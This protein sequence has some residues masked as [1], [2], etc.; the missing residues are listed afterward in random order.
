MG[1]IILGMTIALGAL[2][3]F[4]VGL[5]SVGSGAILTPILLIDF[6]SVLSKSLVVGTSTMYGTVTKPIASVRNYVR[7]SLKLDYAFIIAIT[8]VPFSSIGAFYSGA[9]LSWN[10]FPPI[11]AGILILAALGM[12]MQVRVNGVGALKD[13]EMS[14]GLRIKGLL[15]G[16]AVGLIAGLTGVST[17]SLMVASLILFL[18]FP[19]RTAVGIAIF[20]GGLILAAATITQLYLG[21]VNLPFTGLLVLGGVPGILLGSH[22]KDKVD[23]GLLGYGIAGVIILESARTLSNFLFGKSFF[24]F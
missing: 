1:P 17:G 7:R 6:A 9:F 12:I 4:L 2:V 10:L 11:L 14:T 16:I 13:P 23:Q 19:N 3:G 24:I 22:Y 21:H 15:L 8:G 18:K 20:E 5:T